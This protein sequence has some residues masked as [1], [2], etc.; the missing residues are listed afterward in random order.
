[1]PIGMSRWGSFASCAA[2]ETASKPMQAK[3]TT[4][5]PRTTP[6]QPKWPNSPG[7]DGMRGCQLAE[8]PKAAPG[9]MKAATRKSVTATIILLSRADSLVPPISIAVSARTIRA[10]GM[11]TMPPT[12]VP[13]GSL[14]SVQGA[15]AYWGGMGMPELRNSDAMSTDQ[16]T[17]TV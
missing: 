1:M 16:P 13:S 11:L 12:M 17:A 9:R 14:T 15:T 10:A 5:A 3:N 2:V 6:D 7:L 4:E 8:A